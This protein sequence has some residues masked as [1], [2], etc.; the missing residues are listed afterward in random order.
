[1]VYLLPGRMSLADLSLP[2]GEGEGKSLSQPQ[3][4]SPPP[5]SHY[6]KEK[7][8]WSH[9]ANVKILL[10]LLTNKTPLFLLTCS[11]LSCFSLYKYTIETHFNN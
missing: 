9:M 3:T 4:V 6:T 8:T 10:L 5:P 2:L 11:A 7:K 1:M